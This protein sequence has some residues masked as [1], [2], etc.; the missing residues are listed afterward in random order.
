MIRVTIQ[1]FENPSLLTMNDISVRTGR[2]QGLYKRA[3][4]FGAALPCRITWITIPILENP[5]DETYQ[6][7]QWPVLLPQDFVS[8][9]P[10]TFVGFFLVPM[11]G[12]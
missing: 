9:Q 11:L 10:W 2:E 3:S 8:Y 1:G 7:V 4:Q 12:C 5:D 6:L